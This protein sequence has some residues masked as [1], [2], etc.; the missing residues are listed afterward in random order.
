MAVCTLAL[1]VF[2][3]NKKDDPADNDLFVGTYKGSVSFT[4]DK[5]NTESKDDGSVIVAK[6][7]DSYNFSFSPG[8][9]LTGVKFRKEK[10]NTFVNVDFKD[11]IQYITITNSSL[12]MLYMKD[13]KTW[14]ANAKR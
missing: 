3:C 1:V 6:V 8:E 4:D 9:T 13:G 7:G 2:S 12:N 11:G 10:D 5:G 14:K